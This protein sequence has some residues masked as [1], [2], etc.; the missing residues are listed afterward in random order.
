MRDDEKRRDRN[1]DLAALRID[2]SAAAH[3]PRRWRRLPPLGVVLALALGLG[4]A[5]R[6]AFGREPQVKVAYARAVG[7]RDVPPAVALT[8]SGYIVTADHYISLGVRVPGRIEAYLVEEGEHVRKGQRLVQLDDRRYKAALREARAALEE[9]KATRA[10]RHKEL[11]RAG[12]LREEGVTSQADLDLK[13]ARSREADAKVQTLV[14][15]IAQLELDLDDT[16]LRSPVNGVVLERLK[17]AGEIAVPGGFAGSG[18]LLRV[19]NLDELRAQ[20][21]IN[22]SDI[23]NVHMGQPAEVVPDAFP[24]R[25]YPAQVVKLAAQV[26]RQKGTLQVEARILRPDDALRPDMSARVDFLTAAT[27]ATDSAPVV[28]VPRGALRS[29]E[30][31][32]FVWVV[33]GGRV[34]H[35]PVQANGNADSDP[36]ALTSGLD[37]GEALVIGDARGLTEGLHVRVAPGS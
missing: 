18:E 34:E 5:W 9:A 21:D 1:D 28:L 2:R 26:N 19:A 24:D 3:P 12:E 32:L 29:G 31:G 23:R 8:G 14:A 7:A 10:L 20:V 36:V 25:R 37:G 4:L 17:E 16:V 30:S 27:P 6:L 15:R 33:R 35:Q 22:E 11:E 13:L